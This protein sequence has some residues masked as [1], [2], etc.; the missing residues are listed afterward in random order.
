MIGHNRACA[1]AHE[2]TVRIGENL[3]QLRILV[4]YEVK[5]IGI[6]FLQRTTKKSSLGYI[7][8]ESIINRRD[9][10]HINHEADHTRP[11]FL[12]GTKRKV[13]YA[14]RHLHKGSSPSKKP[15]E[16]VSL[17]Q[18]RLIRFEEPRF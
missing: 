11:R 13:G 4:S 3:F 7:R 12:V 18:M 17:Y 6:G 16:P 14:Q 15:I 10:Q 9:V 2:A 1:E 5:C 8:E